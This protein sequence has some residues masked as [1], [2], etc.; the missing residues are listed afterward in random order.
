LVTSPGYPTLHDPTDSRQ[1]PLHPGEE[2]AG[3]YRIENVIGAGAMGVVVRAW[4]IE[5][6]QP[7]AVKFLYPE[8][9]RNSDGAERFRREARAAAKIKNQHVARV[10][11]VGTLLCG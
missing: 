7:V 10:L 11:D 6:E 1:P 9:A 3:K 8:F 4:H 2:L 5:L